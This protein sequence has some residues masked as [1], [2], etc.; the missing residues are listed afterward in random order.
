MINRRFWQPPDD[1]WWGHGLLLAA[2]SLIIFIFFTG[3]WWWRPRWLFADTA[4]PFIRDALRQ[5]VGT[6]AY[7]AISFTRFAITPFIVAL[8]ILWLLMGMRG[9]AQLVLSGRWYWLVALGLLIFWIF[10]SMG[11]VAENQYVAQNQVGQW[12]MVFLFVL[13]VS[14]VGPSSRVIGAALLAGAVFQAM[15]GIIQTLLQHDLGIHWLDDNTLQLGLGLYEFSLN[16]TASGTSVI[17]SNDVRFLRAYGITPHPNLLAP[18]LVMGLLSGWWLWERGQ[19]RVVSIF[20][21]GIVLWG[22]FLTF[23]RAALGG[24]IVGFMFLT[25]MLYWWKISRVRTL[26]EYMAFIL[27]L[28]GLF[29][30]VYQPLVDVRA[31]IGDEGATSLEGIS[32][33]SRAVYL[34]QAET[35]IREHP[36]R[37]VGIGNFPYVSQQMLQAQTEIDLRGDNVHR[38]YYLIVAEIGLVGGLLFATTGLVVLGFLWRNRLQIA[39]STWGLIAAI[40]A[41][42]ALG[43]FEFSWWVLMPY[44][45]LFWGVIA[46]IMRDAL[47]DKYTTH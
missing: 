38:V 37:G 27:M 14:C 44:Q 21:I 31:G 45:L 34:A 41:W 10:L 7:T 32:V 8:V 28:G 46:I 22:L 6:D 33:E 29:Y 20:T 47:P 23:S 17:Q 36:L 1:N 25:M 24:Y 4:P 12:V 42:L 26:L 19:S 9:L 5:G 11:W 43:W 35:M 2:Q 40:M 30:I 15:I 13:I 18:V 16:P 39:L 3:S